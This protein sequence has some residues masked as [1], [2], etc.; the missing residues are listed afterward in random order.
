MT[1]SP[2]CRCAT[3]QVSA[4]VRLLETNRPMM[5]LAI[6]RPLVEAM[7]EAGEMMAAATP[8]AAPAERR[9][10]ARATTLPVERR[11][12]SERPRKPG[13][14]VCSQRTNSA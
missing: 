2:R 9:Q 5:A 12:R 4:A 1:T 13:K 7:R 14:M 8:P 10:P 3:C 6:L 11:E